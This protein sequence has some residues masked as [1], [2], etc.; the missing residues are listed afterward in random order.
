MTIKATTKRYLISSLVTFFTGVG[1]V[2]LSQW[3]S[4]SLQ[5]FKD[6]TIVGV[7]F[8]AVRAGFKA[9]IEYLLSISK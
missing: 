3:D 5:A 8:V 6:G 4:I 1:V 9:L 2:L 7:V